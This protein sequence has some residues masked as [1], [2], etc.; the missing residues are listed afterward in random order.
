MS[1]VFT[2][3]EFQAALNELSRDIHANNTHWW[4]DL[5]T[6]EPLY[7]RPSIVPEKMMLIVREVSEAL[8]GHRKGLKDDKLPH[9]SMFEVEMADALIRLMDLCAAYKLDLGGAVMEKIE[10]NKIRE[11]HTDAHR[12]APGGKAY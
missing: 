11:D 8:E 1:K 4:T 6:G 12:K 7:D 2:S 3:L 9:R 10:F 5:Y